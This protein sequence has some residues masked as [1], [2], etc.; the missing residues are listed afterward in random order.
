ME[1]KIINSL[2]GSKLKARILKLFLHNPDSF[3]NLKNVSEKIKMPESYTR[4]EIISLCRLGIIKKS[5]TNEKGKK[6]R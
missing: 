5:K 4:K 3:F 1:D 2:F 6:A